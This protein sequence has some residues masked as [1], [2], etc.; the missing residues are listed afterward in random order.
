MNSDM[1]V[2]RLKRMADLARE[3][4]QLDAEIALSVL[5]RRVDALADDL[6]KGLFDG[7]AG[8]E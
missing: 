4:A 3:G 7:D 5:T 1:V 2:T 8:A 6:A